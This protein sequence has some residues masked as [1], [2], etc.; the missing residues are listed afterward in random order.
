[1]PK[2]PKAARVGAARAAR[3]G[4]ARADTK[5]VPMREVMANISGRGRAAEAATCVMGWLVNG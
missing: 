5:G 3:L 4:A 1:L 2:P